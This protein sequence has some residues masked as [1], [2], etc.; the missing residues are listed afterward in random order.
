LVRSRAIV[1][2]MVW[3]RVRVMVSIK[4]IVKVRFKFRTRAIDPFG[5]GKV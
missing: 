2:V 1:T 4:V 3:G 5:E